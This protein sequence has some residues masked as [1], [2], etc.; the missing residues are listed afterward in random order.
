MRQL[1][2]V[3]TIMKSYRWK[4]SSDK[5]FHDDTA[6]FISKSVSLMLK[7]SHFRLINNNGSHD[8]KNSCIITLDGLLLVD[9]LSNRFLGWYVQKFHRSLISVVSG[10][11][12]VSYRILP[13]V[14]PTSSG[15]P[16]FVLYSVNSLKW[17]AH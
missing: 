6:R 13:L 10:P 12:I 7:A 4:Q 1:L 17:Q 14:V 8:H 3:V 15:V 16:F 2:Y 11:E 9:M 5:S